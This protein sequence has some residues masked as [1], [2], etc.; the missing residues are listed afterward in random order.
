MLNSEQLKPILENSYNRNDWYKILR[1][2]FNVNVLREN[3]P[4]IVSVAGNE[5]NATA[6]ELG[7]FNTT[8]GHKVGIY[9][10]AVPV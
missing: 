5:F 3:P 7:D 1:Q 8:E 10:V 6:Y 9:E 4:P 2:N